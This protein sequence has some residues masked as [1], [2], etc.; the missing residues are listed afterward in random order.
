MGRCNK[1]VQEV[2]ELELLNLYSSAIVKTGENKRS[3]YL[4][5][6]Y[7]KLIQYCS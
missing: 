2:T 1:R 6:F 4:A 7:K 5:W 3:A